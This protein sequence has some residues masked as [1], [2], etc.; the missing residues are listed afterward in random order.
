[1]SHGPAVITSQA[2][3]ALA[4][5]PQVNFNKDSFEAVIYQKGYRVYHDKAIKCPCKV[6]ATDNLSD[7][8]NCGGSGWVFYNRVSTR[9]ILHSMNLDTQYKEWSE[10]TLGTVNITAR[11]VDKIAY[12]DRITVIDAQTLFSEVIYPKK[13]KGLRYATATYDI[14]SIEDVFLFAGSKNKLTRLIEGTDYTLNENAIQLDAKYDNYKSTCV[15]LRYIHSP[16]YHVI[17]M[18]R[19]TM[20]SPIKNLSGIP[21]DKLMPISAVGRRAHYVLDAQNYNGDYLFDN[22]YIDP[23]A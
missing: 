8:H 21:E 1:M 17:D 4:G 2:A 10:E 16:T 5:Q 19:D 7:C 12:M 14:L 3:P 23:C 15:A 11:D 20:D 18:P 6:Q 22:S 9:M 13:H